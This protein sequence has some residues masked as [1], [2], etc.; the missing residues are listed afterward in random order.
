MPVLPEYSLSG[1]VALLATA[2]GYQAPYLAQALAEAEASVFTVARRQALLD[3]V[4]EALN[5]SVA[6]L[7]RG[8]SRGRES[9]RAGPGDGSLRPPA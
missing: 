5:S 1:K 7:R 9:N 3:K 4:L 2:G 8:C 6:G